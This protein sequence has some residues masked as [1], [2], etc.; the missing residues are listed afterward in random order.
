M[1]ATYGI[2]HLKEGRLLAWQ[3]TFPR[4]Q[5]GGTTQSV[6]IVCRIDDEQEARRAAEA[7]LQSA[8]SSYP[9]ISGD[10]LSD[11]AIEMAVPEG[12]CR[13]IGQND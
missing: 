2:S 3:F 10:H 6:R 9:L 7:L 8:P 11:E 4:Q 5:T 1:R 13:I 12:E